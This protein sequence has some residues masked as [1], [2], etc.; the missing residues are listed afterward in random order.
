MNILKY[1]FLLLTMIF[2]S[3]CG[4]ES[5]SN[6]SN[7]NDNSAQNIGK[8]V[9]N[10]G[11]WD[12]VDDFINDNFTAST[13]PLIQREARAKQKLLL[14]ADDREKTIQNSQESL[15]AVA[16]ISD[17][18]GSKVMISYS[19]MSILANTKERSDAYLKATDQLS[20]TFSK[21]S[22]NPCD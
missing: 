19:M 12:Y 17:T 9:D 22:K 4:D 13:R 20:G 7:I 8:D 1:P 3:N 2:I 6:T 21:M 16:C 18:L 15:N 14:E 10:N 11:V 5:S